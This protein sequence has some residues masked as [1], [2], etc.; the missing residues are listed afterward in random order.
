MQEDKN[1]KYGLLSFVKWH[2]HIS[3]ALTIFKYVNN[4]KILNCKYSVVYKQK[5]PK[6]KLKS[7]I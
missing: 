6:S 1:K 7:K 5:S 4:N 3:A 2:T